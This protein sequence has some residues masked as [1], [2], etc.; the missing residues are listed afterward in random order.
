MISEEDKHNYN[1]LI[2]IIKD[3]VVTREA[4]NVGKSKP[5]ELVQRVKQKTVVGLS[6][7]DHA[8]FYTVFGIRPPPSSEQDPFETNTNYCHYDEAHNDYLYQEAWVDFIVKILESKKITRSKVR[9]LGRKGIK[10]D[11]QDY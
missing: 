9:E 10:L 3:K 7:N 8:C 5:T 6:T 2:T 11:I 4:I 1:K